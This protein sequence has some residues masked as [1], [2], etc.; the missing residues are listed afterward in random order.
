MMRLCV[1]C[2]RYYPPAQFGPRGGRLCGDCRVKKAA[3]MRGYNAKRYAEQRARKRGR[4]A[5][6]PA[7]LRGWGYV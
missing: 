7:A 3:Y 6:A 1:I 4:V 5:R 2:K